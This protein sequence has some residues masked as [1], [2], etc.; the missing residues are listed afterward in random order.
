M[1]K[2]YTIYQ[3]TNKLNGMIYIG[4]HITKNLND[5][6]MG[7]GTN[8][9]KVIKESGKEN[10][11]K[12]ILFIFDNKEDMLN[13]EAELV[14]RKFIAR[15]DTYN[16]ILGGFGFITIDCVVV[17]DKDNNKIL[18]HKTD[19]RYLS[20]ELVSSNKGLI[21]TKDKDGKIHIIN[22]N[23]LRWIN[24][25]LVGVSKGYIKVID[26]NNNI[27]KVDKNDEKLL[28]GELKPI[29]KNK[30]INKKIIEKKYKYIDLQRNIYY[31]NDKE[32]INDKRILSGKIFKFI[33]E[34]IIVKNKNNERFYL[35]KNDDQILSGELIKTNKKWKDKINKNRSFFG[36]DN[37][38]GGKIGI[39]NLITHKRKYVNKEE[40]DEYLINNW[41]IGWIYKK[42]KSRE[43][44]NFSGLL[45]SKMN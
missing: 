12:E 22:K 2:F 37:S 15:K 31:F 17:K 35:H 1:S 26:K 40:L 33:K 5:N 38:I 14:D 41:Q 8:I 7:S 18:V 39:T 32:I 36:S 16:I 45:N 29:S 6:Y 44:A 24:K 30:I 10:F 20:G 13:K 23:D 34:Y 27:R 28:T 3:I 4:A 9:K 42:Q 19:E 25:E 21:T 11:I 43:V